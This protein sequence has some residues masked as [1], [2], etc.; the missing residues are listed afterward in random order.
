MEQKD[1][2]EKKLGQSIDIV[3]A[4]AAAA[5]T[6][7]A[8]AVVSSGLD[9]SELNKK[10]CLAQQPL[11]RKQMNLLF[12]LFHSVYKHTQAKDS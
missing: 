10:S 5:K 11:E 12:L 6:L 8:M 3:Q 4:A 7:M 9:R 2:E 1:G